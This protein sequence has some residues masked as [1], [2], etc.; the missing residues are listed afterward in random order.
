[1]KIVINMGLK[2]VVA[3][4]LGMLACHC[5]YGQQVYVTSNKFEADYV[6]FITNNRYEADNLIYVTDNRFEAGWPCDEVDE[7]FCGRWFMTDNKYRANIKVYFTN[8]RFEAD[9][10]IYYT[11]NKYEAFFEL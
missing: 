3:F 8:N 2:F 10:K 1:M 5:Y 4:L 11:T 6:M 9:R 7:T